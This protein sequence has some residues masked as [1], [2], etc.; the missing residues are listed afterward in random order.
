MPKLYVKNVCHPTIRRQPR[1]FYWCALAATSYWRPIRIA[2]DEEVL[3]GELSV[4]AIERIIAHH[5]QYGLVDACSLPLRPEF[6]G[7]AYR[8][9]EE[10]PAQAA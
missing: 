9:V 2:P 7:L 6:E 5:E 1:E 3:V 10:E 4:E 8:I